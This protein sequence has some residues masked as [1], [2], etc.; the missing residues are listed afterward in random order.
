MKFKFAWVLVVLVL[1]SAGLVSAQSPKGKPIQI[2]YSN[3][4]NIDTMTQWFRQVLE[5]LSPIRTLIG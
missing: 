5:K 1:A 4:S 2:G 3:F